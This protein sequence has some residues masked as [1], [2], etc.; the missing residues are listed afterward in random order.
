MLETVVTIIL[1]PIAVMAV[2]FTGCLLVGVARGVKKAKN[3][4]RS[5]TELS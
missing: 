1:V 4:V 5:C 3:S 2:I